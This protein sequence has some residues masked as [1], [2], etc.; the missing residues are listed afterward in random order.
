ML[1]KVLK[2]ILQFAWGVVC[3]AGSLARSFK[4]DN[5]IFNIF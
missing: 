2:C 4:Y 3:G 5:D 1:W